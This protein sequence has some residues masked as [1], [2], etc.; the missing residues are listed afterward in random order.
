MPAIEKKSS[1]SLKISA[2]SD[3]K[4]EEAMRIL[5]EKLREKGIILISPI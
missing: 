4:L 1:A 3:E 2:V 5:A